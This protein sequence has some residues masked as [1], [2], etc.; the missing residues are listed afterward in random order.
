M[1]AAKMVTMT[2]IRKKILLVTCP[3]ILT[4]SLLHLISF[5]STIFGT[6]S[7]QFLEGTTLGVGSSLTSAGRQES[8]R[9]RPGV[10]QTSPGAEG[11]V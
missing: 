6:L 11:G 3:T 10:L 7:P 1:G 5:L 9:R 4:C 8:G 2:M